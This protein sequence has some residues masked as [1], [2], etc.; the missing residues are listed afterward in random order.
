MA[1]QVKNPFS[2]FL[3]ILMDEN[4]G[5]SSSL[6]KD[7]EKFF[8]KGQKAASTRIRKKLTQIQKFCKDTKR[9][10]SQIKAE[11]KAASTQA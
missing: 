1:D 6:E 2:D 7:F 11:R 9:L 5:E 10:I 4:N 8:E 3:A